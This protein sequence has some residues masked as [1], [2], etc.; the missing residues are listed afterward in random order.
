MVLKPEL[1][2]SYLAW[3]LSNSKNMNMKNPLHYIEIIPFKISI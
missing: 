3:K 2:K 1:K